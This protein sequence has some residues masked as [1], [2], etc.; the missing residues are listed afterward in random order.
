MSSFPKAVNI[1]IEHNNSFSDHDYCY[2]ESAV[3]EMDEE[4]RS[5][6]VDVENDD[7]YDDEYNARGRKRRNVKQPDFFTINNKANNSNTKKTPKAR[8]RKSESKKGKSGEKKVKYEVEYIWGKR[9]DKLR[10]DKME[11]RVYWK[12]Y[13]IEKSTWEPEDNL[14]LCQE[15]IDRYEQREMYFNDKGEKE[16]HSKGL[17]KDNTAGN[18]VKVV[19][20]NGAKPLKQILP[21]MQAPRVVASGSVSIPSLPKS[22]KKGQKSAS[23]PK[24]V[25]IIR[26]HTPSPQPLSGEPLVGAKK[27]KASTASLNGISSGKSF[28]TTSNGNNKIESNVVTAAKTIEELASKLQEK[29][30]DE[31]LSHESCDID[32][33]PFVFKARYGDGKEKKVIMRDLLDIA[34]RA[35]ACYLATVLKQAE[36]GG[37]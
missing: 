7:E 12:G 18:G 24:N 33:V 6:F 35:L 4:N 14:R 32:G 15:S 19:V 29:T 16:M 28:Q 13:P 1:K 2:K 20:V 22:H 25:K 5:F 30:V 36:E 11:Y 26:K 17:K 31:I 34:P 23:I 27:R 9:T 8:P 3:E 37:D 10:P 21:T